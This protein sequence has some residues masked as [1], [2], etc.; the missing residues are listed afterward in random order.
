LLWKI[1]AGPNT[2]KEGW[3][4]PPGFSEMKRPPLSQSLPVEKPLTPICCGSVFRACKLASV[5]GSGLD[6]AWLLD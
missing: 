6:D 3:Q 5:V 4:D 1:E 2:H